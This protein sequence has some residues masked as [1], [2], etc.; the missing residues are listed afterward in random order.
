MYLVIHHCTLTQS[1]KKLHQ[2][3]SHASNGWVTSGTCVY[4]DRSR[5]C[6]TWLNHDQSSDL[7]FCFSL[8]LSRTRVSLFYTRNSHQCH[9]WTLYRPAEWY[10]SAPCLCSAPSPLLPPVWEGCRRPHDEI[11][12]D[13]P[14]AWIVPWRH[15]HIQPLKIKTDARVA[16][17]FHRSWECPLIN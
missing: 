4:Q 17:F 12:S 5:S 2:K 14:S 9:K 16:K 10:G 6:A 3:C 11:A 8:S 13:Y 15:W 1:K 7:T